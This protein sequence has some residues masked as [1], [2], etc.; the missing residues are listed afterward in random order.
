MQYS[1]FY[2]DE[3]YNQVK[4]KLKSIIDNDKYISTNHVIYIRYPESSLTIEKF[5]GFR[6]RYNV[7]KD[8]FFA[9]VIDDYPIKGNLE[10]FLNKYVETLKNIRPCKMCTKLIKNNKNV[11]LKCQTR[12]A[13]DLS[14]FGEECCICQEK[15]EKDAKSMKCCGKFIHTNCYK[16]YKYKKKIEIE[17][18]C[19]DCSE[20]LCPYCRSNCCD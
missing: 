18:C 8:I 7:E 2:S 9:F 5:F 14:I 4:E 12:H 10:D 1:N 11:C 16:I 13:C 20:I 17:D 6:I 3:I 15:I 19:D